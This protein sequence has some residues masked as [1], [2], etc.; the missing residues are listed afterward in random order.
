MDV[1][2]PKLVHN[3][4]EFLKEY[5]IIVVGVLTALF[6]EQA[7]QSIEWHHKVD[8]AIADMNNELRAAG[9]SAAGHARVCRNPAECSS[10]VAGERRPFT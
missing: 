2:K 7:V 3:W 4:R 8:A 9:L 6:A 5:A 10:G 1:H